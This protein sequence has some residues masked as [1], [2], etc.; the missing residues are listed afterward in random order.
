MVWNNGGTEL[1][2]LFPRHAIPVD[3]TEAYMGPEHAKWYNSGG[4][5]GKKLMRVDQL[6]LAGADTP[7]VRSGR[8]EKSSSTNRTTTQRPGGRSPFRGRG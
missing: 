6:M 4:K 1:L 2:Y 7:V 8:A 5:L 3:P